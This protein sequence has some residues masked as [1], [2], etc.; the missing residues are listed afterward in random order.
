MTRMDTQAPLPDL[1]Q[2]L[3]LDQLC[4]LVELP[5]RTVRYYIQTGLVSRPV[6]EK[7]GAYYTEAHLAQLM[8]IRKWQQAGLSLDR[9]S[10]LLAGHGGDQPPPRPRMPGTVEV[11]SHLV[12][13]DGLEINLEPNRA[14]LSPEQSRAF[15][16]EISA[17][18]RRIT[19]PQEE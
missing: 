12:V 18:Y 13:A 1:P 19:E 15:F 11:W 7:R 6:G 5:K 9:I 14:G 4:S 16:R 10:E 2:K 3:S 17:L 8:A